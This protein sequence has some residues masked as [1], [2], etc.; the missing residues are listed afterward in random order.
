MH[1]RTTSK[2]GSDSGVVAVVPSSPKS[3]D[4]VPD[5]GAGA[6]VM[7]EVREEVRT[8]PLPKGAVQAAQDG[9]KQHLQNMKNKFQTVKQ[10]SANDPDA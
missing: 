10:A 3:K 9:L 7:K 2:D 1:A 5:S 6:D 8:N 4:V